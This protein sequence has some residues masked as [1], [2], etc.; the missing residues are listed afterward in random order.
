MGKSAK[1]ILDK[2]GITVGDDVKVIL[3]EA[4]EDHPFVQVELMMP[5]LPLVRVPDVDQAIEMAVRVE[6]G[7]RHTAMMHS[8]NVEKLTKMAKLIQTTIFVKNGPSYAGIGVGGEGYTTFYHR[9]S[10]RRG[11]DF[12]QIL[13]PAPQ[14]RAR[15]RDGRQINGGLGHYARESARP[16]GTGRC[17]G[18]GGADFP[19]M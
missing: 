5:I 15:R 14:M 1:Y 6:H 17:G 3:M 7:N 12:G 4:K 16:G 13:C 11:P 10:H 9:R 8:R 2:I 19:P 18:R